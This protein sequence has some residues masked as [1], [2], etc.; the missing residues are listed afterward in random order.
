M[1]TN[2][3][4]LPEAFV[5]FAQKDTYSKGAADISVTSLIDSPRVRMMKDHY[6]NEISFDVIDNIWALFG[7][8]VHHILESAKSETLIKEER[9]FVDID[10]WTLSGAIDQQEVDDD[11]INIIDYKVTSVWSVIYD[12][13]SWHEQLNCY[14]HLIEMNKDKP[15][16]SLKICAILRDWQQRD[17]R[18]K[19]N[20]PQAPIVLVDIPLWSFAERD[21]YVRSRM[22]L[23]KAASDMAN[24]TRQTIEPLD[25]KFTPYGDELP[26]DA[27]FPQ[28]SDEERWTQPEKWAIMLKGRKKAAKLCET[29][30][31]AEHIMATED[32][33][34][35]PYL[36]HR[37]GEPKRCTGNYCSVADICHQWKEERE[38]ANG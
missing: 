2:K 3:H 29:K 5:N 17:A 10:G 36:E 25:K 13:S 19:D 7:T 26:V 27:Y 28:C 1:I 23:H 38:L 4:N 6:K 24:L 30:E 33:K 15:V 34:G 31:Q 12:K 21:V 9:L 16:K 11:G 35:K 37:K 8:A 18:N 32:F 22:A 20:Y 14:A